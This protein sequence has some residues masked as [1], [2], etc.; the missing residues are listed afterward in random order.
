MI[1]SSGKRSLP[2]RVVVVV[3]GQI[4]VVQGTVIERS[5]MQRCAVEGAVVGVWLVVDWNMDV[6][7][8]V[9]VDLEWPQKVSLLDGLAFLLLFFNG[10]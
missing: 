10:F 4:V 2:V 6:L 9:F 8:D 5:V 7:D 1:I 3:W